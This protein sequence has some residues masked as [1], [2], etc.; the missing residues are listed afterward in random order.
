MGAGC[1]RMYGFRTVGGDMR[2]SRVT[3][4]GRGKIQPFRALSFI[5]NTTGRKPFPR[6]KKLGEHRTQTSANSQ[7]SKPLFKRFL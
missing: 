5:C 1:L 4:P 3:L 2:L 7:V 6:L